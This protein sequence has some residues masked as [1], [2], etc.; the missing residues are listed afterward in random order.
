[1][2]EAILY[3]KFPNDKSVGCNLCSH[4]CNIGN[5]EKGKCGVRQNINGTLF[6]LNYGIIQGLAIDPIEKKPLYHYFPGSQLISFGLPG[7]NFHCFNCQNSDLSQCIKENESLVNS[8]EMILPSKFISE[9]EN[10]NALGIA[11]TYSEPTIFFEYIYDVINYSKQN[12]KTINYKHI[13]VSNGYFSYEL[14]SL[15][16]N[17]KLIDAM[18][19]DLKFSN[20]KSYRTFTG[21]SMEPIISNIELLIDA[22][23]HI[24]I[25]NLIIPDIN[26][27]VEDLIKFSEIVASINSRIPVHFTGFFPRYKMSTIEPTKTSI[28]EKA[29]R[30]ALEAGI[31]Y[32]FIGNTT[33]L[34]ESNTCCPECGM[35][36][37]ERNS[38]RNIKLNFIIEDGK[39]VCVHCKQIQD[40][41]I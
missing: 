1:M 38:Y 6:S 8:S 18:N 41:T 31:K 5:N 25:T 9:I 16:I 40:L 32:V 14:I 20:D 29:K 37:I 4:Y 19:I 22:G 39:A 3:K 21:G 7:C 11:Y 36:I 12:E 30:V 23:I 24:E 35:I 34:Q 27:S 26:D 2:I 33:L 10:I 15:I 28:L 13:L 17:E